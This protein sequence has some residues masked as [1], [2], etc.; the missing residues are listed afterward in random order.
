[1]NRSAI[2]SY[3]AFCLIIGVYALML[4]S[5]HGKTKSSSSAEEINELDTAVVIS[6]DTVVIPEDTMSADDFNDVEYSDGVIPAILEAS[7][8]YA[9]RLAREGSDGFI[10]VDKARMKVILYDRYGIAQR[11]Y[12]M[13]CS[14]NYGTK[15]KKGDLRTPEGFFS[16]EG[17]Y[18]STE[19]LFTD[20]NGVTSKKKG[21]FGPRFIRLKIPN[22]SQIGIHGT[23]A[24]WTI[25]HRSSHG[26]IRITNENIL[27]L[28]ELVHV[29]MPVIVLPGKR[30]RLVNREE[31]SDIVY[32][33]TAP[34]Y[35]LSSAEKK[36][37]ENI[38]EGM[39]NSETDKDSLSSDSKISVDSIPIS[40]HLSE[41]TDTMNNS[42]G[43]NPV[44]VETF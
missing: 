16:V 28:V 29:G 43:N 38:K 11:T 19:W 39:E 34:G 18:D 1:M 27:E 13:A 32:F 30:D 33:A 2:F 10:I 4:S 21:Q 36:V 35:A 20:D 12:G 15:L 41:K 9:E 17:V 31:G 44:E 24:P 5:C 37:I 42:K 8:E 25:G 40:P 3:I 23:C 6:I 22:T 26:C 7:P 14:K